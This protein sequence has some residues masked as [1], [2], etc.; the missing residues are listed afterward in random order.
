MVPERSYG[1]GELVAVPGLNDDTGKPII[2]EVVAVLPGSPPQ[3][4][5]EV[6][7]IG[8]IDEVPK[9]DLDRANSAQAPDAQVAASHAIVEVREG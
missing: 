4:R 2:G 6:K 7:G 5:I 9:T 8:C 1:T 3:V